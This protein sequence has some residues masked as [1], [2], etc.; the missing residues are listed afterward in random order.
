MGHGCR[1]G[2][3]KK[4]AALPK[5]GQEGENHNA[6]LSAAFEQLADHFTKRG[7][8]R[9]AP[10]N[11]LMKLYVDLATSVGRGNGSLALHL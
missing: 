3:A 7:A 5:A 11:A 9:F 8:P 2:A 1:E 6:E 10:F 4:Q